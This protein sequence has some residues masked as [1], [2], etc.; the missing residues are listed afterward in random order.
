[1]W[2][3]LLNPTAAIGTLGAIAGPL[4]NYQGAKEANE[5]NIEMSQANSAFN[6]AEAQ[7]NRDFQE[8]QRSTQYQVATEDMKKAGINPMVAFMKGGAG[9]TS[10]AQAAAVSTPAVSN[11]FE[12]ALTASAQV[13]AIAM[14]KAS[15]DKIVADTDVSRAQAAQVRAQ[16]LN[17]TASTENVTQQTANLKES[18][19]QI[20]E[21]IA[22]TRQQRLTSI[23]E[24]GLKA[25]Q[26]GL[27]SMEQRLAY[28]KIN[29]TD[30]QTELT[31]ITSRLSTLD[32]PGK[33]NA[34]N[35]EDTW[36]GRNVR[37]YLRDF[38]GAAS[39]TNSA[40]KALGR[41]N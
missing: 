2:E 3:T 15:I 40:A 19:Q 39:G 8:M 7:K 37:P 12:A 23:Q 30:A 36:W 16:T 25:A 17:T 21:N 1:M 9:T 28:H 10:G 26:A 6:A 32:I 5:T 31:K 14:Q 41:S 20:K 33:T 22:Y 27:T 34:A 35:S 4:L 18:I 38:S 11:K 24:E 29:L 13:A